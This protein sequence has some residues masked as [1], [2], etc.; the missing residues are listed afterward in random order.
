MR[1]EPAPEYT[2][3]D[4]LVGMNLS[5]SYL[6]PIEKGVKSVMEQGVIAGYPVVDFEAE[7]FFG[8][9]H[10]VDSSDIAFQI[11]G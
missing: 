5:R 3:G 2:F 6:P 8:S 7:C 4:E 10:T 11:A 1:I 9:Y